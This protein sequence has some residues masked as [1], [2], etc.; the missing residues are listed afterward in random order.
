MSAEISKEKPW[1][2]E[3]LAFW[4]LGLAVLATSAFGWYTIWLAQEVITVEGVTAS[5]Y[6]HFLDGRPNEMGDTLA[7][8]VGSLTLIWVI[9]SVL[10]QSME[11]RAQRREF[12]E[13]VH[14]QEAQ[15][16]ALSAQ[17]AIF[18][19]EK[20]RRDEVEAK[21][22]LDELVLS[23]VF[24]LRNFQN[25]LIK[26]SARHSSDSQQVWSVDFSYFPPEGDMDTTDDYMPSIVRSAV[27]LDKYIESLEPPN[28]SFRHPEITYTQADPSEMDLAIKNTEKIVALRPKLS[29]AQQVRLDRLR[30]EELHEFLHRLR[31]NEQLWIKPSQ[32]GDTP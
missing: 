8:F 24:L 18:Q 16:E 28:A 32:I 10:Q 21:N 12:A 9:A 2:L 20:N 31:Q 15:V 1:W 3:A 23:T 27:G 14:A 6:L 26:K 17:A 19:D 30:V 5:R 29:A 13:M 4:P 22:I 11:L 25:L 7:G